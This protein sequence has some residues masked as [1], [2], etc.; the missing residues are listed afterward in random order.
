[1]EVLKQGCNPPEQKI[2]PDFSLTVKQ[3]SLTMQEDYSGHESTKI[4]MTQIISKAKLPS[5]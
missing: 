5:Q 2:M 4:R 3:F 1:M